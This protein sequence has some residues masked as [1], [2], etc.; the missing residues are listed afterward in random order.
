VNEWRPAISELTETVIDRGA[1]TSGGTLGWVLA[2]CVNAVCI[3]YAALLSLAFE[4][5]FV[6]F[7]AFYL[8]LG[9][10]KLDDAFRVHNAYYGA[11]MVRAFWPLVRVGRRGIEH[12]HA[13][14]AR[15]SGTIVSRGRATSQP[16]MM[17]TNHRSVFDVFFFG[18]WAP[19]NTVALVRGWPFRMPILGWFMRRARYIDME[20]V[21][22]DE[23]V[24]KVRELSQRGVC[25]LCFVE[26]HRSRDGRLQRFQSGAF[27]LAEACHL[28]VLPV[29]MT[30]TEQLCAGASNRL[31][32]ARV[33]IQFFAAVDPMAFPAGK[34]ALRLRRHV[35]SVFRE[36]LGE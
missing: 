3:A 24:E 20:S 5:Y 6:F 15:N 25:C 8:L 13:S 17:V 35:E 21:P 27:R 7:L 22:F 16:V 19:P 9:T 18:T 28:P 36:Y 34:R 23:V 4:I 33:M 32:P 31:G 29:C 30:G 10:G 11:F 26:G 14:G 2:C 12:L 1:C